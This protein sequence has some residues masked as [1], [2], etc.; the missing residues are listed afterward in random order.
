MS[1]ARF[2]LVERRAGVGRD[3]DNGCGTT[4]AKPLERH[5]PDFPKAAARRAEQRG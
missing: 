2:E 1:E 4:V 5:P 3:I